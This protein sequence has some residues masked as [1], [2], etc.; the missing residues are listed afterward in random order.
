MSFYGIGTNQDVPKVY[1]VWLADNAT[2]EDGGKDVSKPSKSWLVL[3]DH[4]KIKEAKKIFGN[5]TINF[6]TDGK[7]HLAGS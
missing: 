3:K 5:T 4:S 2:C 1:Q 7:R 6:T